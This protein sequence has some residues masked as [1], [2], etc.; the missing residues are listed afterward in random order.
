MARRVQHL[1]H[2]AGFHNLS[3]PQHHHV[4]G[5]AFDNAQVV[6]DEEHGGSMAGLEVPDEV[7]NF[8]LNVGIQRGGGLVANQQ[9]RLPGHGHGNHNPLPLSAAEFVGIAL[10]QILGGGE[11]HLLQPLHGPQPGLLAG[12]AQSR[13]DGLRHLF[14][15]PHGGIQGRHGLLEHHGHALTGKLPVCPSEVGIGGK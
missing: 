11:L 2:R 3:V 10:G 15:T 8:F 9:R 12:G 7:Q 1:A 6:G 13:P 14:A 4:V 5:H